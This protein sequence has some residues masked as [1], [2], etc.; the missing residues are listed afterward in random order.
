LQVSKFPDVTVLNLGG[1]YKVARMT[2]DKGT[3][4]ATDCAV[5]K[6]VRTLSFKSNPFSLIN[7]ED[8]VSGI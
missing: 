7:F 5:V 3:T 4:L 8:S 2:T 6:E 1:G